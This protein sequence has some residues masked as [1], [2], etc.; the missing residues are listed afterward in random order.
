MARKRI[1]FSGEAGGVAIIVIAKV[2]WFGG[3]AVD[4]GIL[5][6]CAAILA[7]EILWYARRA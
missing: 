4:W 6:V 7:R 1:G 2:F 3:G 5:I